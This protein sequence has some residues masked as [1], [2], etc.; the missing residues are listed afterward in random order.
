MRIGQHA[1]GVFVFSGNVG[2]EVQNTG[3]VPLHP[4]VSRRTMCS[5]HPTCRRQDPVT[6]EPDLAT[7]RA[8]KAGQTGAAVSP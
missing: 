8:L 6:V 1:T 2:G 3:V 5:R 4:E 7:E